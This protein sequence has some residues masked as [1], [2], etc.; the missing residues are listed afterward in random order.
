[1]DF[2]GRVFVYKWDTVIAQLVKRFSYSRDY[3]D[4]LA[5]QRLIHASNAKK[6]HIQFRYAKD[7]GDMFMTEKLNYL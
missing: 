4:A 3:K 5:I 6:S 1:M 2:N 7:R